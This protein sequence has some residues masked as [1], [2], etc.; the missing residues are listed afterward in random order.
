[1][2]QTLF[3][4]KRFEE[5]SKV[6][7]RAFERTRSIDTYYVIGMCALNLGDRQR[8]ANIFQAIVNNR[9][10]HARARYELARIFDQTG[11]Q[12]RA[13]LG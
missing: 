6:L 12:A 10:K 5:A 9:P 3:S 4:L 8:A 11:S 2:G 1:M 7:S 13:L